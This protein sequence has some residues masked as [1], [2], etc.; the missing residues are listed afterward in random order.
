METATNYSNG[1][2]YRVPSRSFNRSI[3]SGVARAATHE[4]GSS[5]RLTFNALSTVAIL[6]LLGGIAVAAAASY[7]GAFEGML[8]FVFGVEVAISLICFAVVLKWMRE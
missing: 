2:Q 6:N 1:K 4:I 3:S 5:A 8:T 7:T